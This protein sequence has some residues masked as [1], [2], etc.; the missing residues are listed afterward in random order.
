MGIRT[1]PDV[2]NLRTSNAIGVSVILHPTT[3]RS[4]NLTK[5]IAMAFMDRSEDRS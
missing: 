3:T 2:Q 1:T 5:Y 4:V